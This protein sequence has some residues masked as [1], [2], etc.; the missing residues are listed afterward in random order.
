MQA[1]SPTITRSPTVDPAKT[2]APV[3]T[4][5]PAPRVV[6]G[7]GSRLA[8]ERGES[9]GCFPTT[10]CS[11]TLTPS[12]RT[13]PSW[14]TAVGWTSGFTSVRAGAERRREP[15]ERP[16]DREPVVRLAMVAGTV[17]DQAE[18]VLELELQRLVV[19]DL[20]AEDVPRPRAPLAVARRRLPGRLLVDGDLP[21]ELHVVEHDHLLPADH[22]H[23]PHLVGVE[24]REVHVGDLPGGEPEEA[25]D[26]VLD[27]LLEVVHA[28][29]DRLA[30]LLAEEP[31][32]DRQV[33][34]PERPERVLVRPDH[35]EVL[36]VAVDARDLAERAGVDELLHRAKTGVVEE[37]VTGHQHEVTRFRERDQLLHLLAAHRRRLLDEDV[38]ARFERLPRQLVVRGHGRRDDHRVDS[39]VGEQLVERTGRARLRVPR[40]VVRQ[41]LLVRVADP[42]E[43]CELAHHADDV[44]SPAA[45]ARVGD[46]AGQSFQTFSLVIPARP[47]AL[48]RSTTSC[49]SSTSR[50]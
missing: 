24:P 37:Q 39:R 14:T 49:A 3:E 44:L 7:S 19:R 21:L 29:R 11:S 8:V 6:G 43:L 50:A 40:G 10:A 18:E 27:P 26:D 15:V 48:R 47:V 28:V 16:H 42:C 31:E 25:E 20:R 13:V 5:V 2:I 17:C 33:V 45:D 36:P 35:A 9:V 30:R 32:D 46:A 4:T 1:W 22:R 23:L 12:P 38:L 41:P 34:H